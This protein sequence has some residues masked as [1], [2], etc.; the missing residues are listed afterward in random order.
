M[1]GFWDINGIS[2]ENMNRLGPLVDGIVGTNGQYQD[3]YEAMVDPAGPLWTKV[4]VC[5][6]CTMSQDVLLGAAYQ[7]GC[8]VSLGQLVEIGRKKLTIDCDDFIMRNVLIR[9]TTGDGLV[10]SE[11]RTMLDGVSILYSG[12]YGIKIESAGGGGYHK[13][14]NSVV[15]DNGDDGI[16]I[17]NG[18]SVYIAGTKIQANAGYG[19]DDNNASTTAVQMLGNLVT[20][21][22]LGQID[23][24]STLIAANRT[25]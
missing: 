14:I 24:V 8:I 15:Y 2:P 20:G 3:L 6:G 16:E 25:A 17:A 5:A 21:N 7:S 9:S 13:I 4:I 18:M 19:I 10:L 12:G 1:S 23:S 22:T 11:D